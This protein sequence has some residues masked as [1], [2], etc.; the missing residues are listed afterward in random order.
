MK[1][2]TLK[3]TIWTASL[4]ISLLSFGQGYDKQPLEK[5]PPALETQYALSALPAHLRPDATVYL[6]DPAS[7]YY[8]A[9]QGSNGFI[10]FVT[11]TEWVWE[12]FRNDIGAAIGYDPEGAR[13]IFPVYLQVAKMRASGKYSP[14]DI[15]N[16]ILDSLRKGIYK[17]PSRAGISYMLAP[18]MRTYPG[19][20]DNKTVK[21]MQMPHYMFYAPYV[22]ASDIGTNQDVWPILVNPEEYFLGEKKG[23]YNYIIMPQGK[24]EIEEIV[25]SNQDLLKKLAD[26]KPYFKVPSDSMHH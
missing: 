2:Q 26:Y 10:C 20:P 24:S 3:I 5:M 7:G 4:F 14:V 13:T 17:A 19:Q 15:R 18:V 12:E 11:R 23:P 8:I 22:S 21:T 1:V 6:L 16:A 9:R 25:K